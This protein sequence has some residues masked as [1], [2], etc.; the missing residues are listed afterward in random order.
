MSSPTQSS[1]GGFV[2]LAGFATTETITQEFPGHTQPTG[3]GGSIVVRFP[4]RLVDQVIDSGLNG[5]S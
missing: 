1:H 2:L 4:Q 3:G 5:K